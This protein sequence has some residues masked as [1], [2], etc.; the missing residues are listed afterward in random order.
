MFVT[1][2][3]ALSSQNKEFLNTVLRSTHFGSKVDLP[4]RTDRRTNSRSIQ[5][6]RLPNISLHQQELKKFLHSRWM[7]KLLAVVN[8]VWFLQART[9]VKAV[10]LARA[11]QAT[12]SLYETGNC[13]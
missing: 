7:L 5:R 9:G 2:L 10:I 8:R 3:V 13:W 1:R 11:R 4:G 6:H 12:L